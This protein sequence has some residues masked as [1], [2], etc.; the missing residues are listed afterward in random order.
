MRSIRLLRA[1]RG[2]NKTA[3]A[4][5]SRSSVRNSAFRAGLE[6][7]VPVPKKGATVWWTFHIPASPMSADHGVK[8]MVATIRMSQ[9]GGHFGTACCICRIAQIPK[10][11]NSDYSLP[12]GP[13]E[14]G[15][16]VALIRTLLAIRNSHFLCGFFRLTR[17]PR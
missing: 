14:T 7:R 13:S 3:S 10:R 15:S 4:R 5:Q 8:S 6:T 16:H 17:G 11:C 1:T 2:S 9:K 12:K